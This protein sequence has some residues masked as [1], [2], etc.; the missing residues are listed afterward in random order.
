MV[1]VVSCVYLLTS[2]YPDKIQSN[3]HRAHCFLPAGIVTVL[4]ERPGLLAPAVSAFYLRDPVDL[5]ACRTFTTFPPETRVLSSVKTSIIH[6]LIALVT[7]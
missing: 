1:G 6:L 2:S 4:A 7:H 3:L 5:Q